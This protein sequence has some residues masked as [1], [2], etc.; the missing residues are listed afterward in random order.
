MMSDLLKAQS[1]VPKTY[2]RF[3]PRGVLKQVFTLRD[4]EIIVDGP[5]GTG[6]SRGLLEKVHLCLTKYKGARGLM[7]R[8]TRA[9]MTETC[10]QTYERKVLNDLDKVHWSTQDQKYTYPNG[11]E[12]VVGG[13]DKATKVMSSEYDIIYVQEA[14]ELSLN[15]WEALSTRLRNGVMPY[16]QQLGDCNPD[17]PRHWIIQRKKAGYL[18]ML[19]SLHKDNPVLWDEVIGNWTEFGQRYWDRLSKLTGVRLLRLRDGIWAA[20]EGVVYEE[21]NPA[22]HIVDWFPIPEEWPTYWAFDFGFNHPFVWKAYAED[23]D[24]TLYVFRQIFMTQR[25]V[26]DHAEHI[27]AIME[28]M[29]QP[30]AIICD[31]DAEGRATLERHLNMPTMPAYKSVWEGIQAVKRRLRPDKQGKPR[32]LYLRD[33]LVEVDQSLSDDEL[34]ICSEDEFTSYVWDKKA[35]DHLNREVPVKRFD[36]GMDCDRYMIAYVDNLAVEPFEDEDELHILDDEERV[37]IS[38]Y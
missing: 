26:E 31:H 28:G 19:Q 33:N 17:D 14:T 35:K 38:R 30:R 22:I 25:I 6:K 27:K 12:L 10:M 18:R 34:P 36:D 11:S 37:I 20:A 5:A 24:G 15:D 13:M 3:K 23:P 32:I 7:V 8:K 29:P 2:I 4:P 1:G 16:Q 9:S 21:W